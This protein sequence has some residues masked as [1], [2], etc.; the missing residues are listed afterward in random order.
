MYLKNTHAG[1]KSRVKAQLPHQEL[2]P[3]LSLHS[4]Q[5]KPVS[6]AAICEAQWFGSL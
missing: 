5:S 1:I 3:D 6:Y 4:L 2:N